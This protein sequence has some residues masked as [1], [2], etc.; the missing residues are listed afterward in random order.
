MKALEY[1]Y[2]LRRVYNSGRDYNSSADADIYRK[3]DRA[4]L[5]LKS[6]YHTNA[7]EGKEYEYRC[8]FSAVRNHISQ[9]LA[10]GIKQIKHQAA[11]E[12]IQ[13]LQKIAGMLRMDYYDREGLDQIIEE[14][15][16]VFRKY[17][18]QGR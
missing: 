6:P 13:Q 8:T 14:A 12:E 3:M 5:H 18:L 15:D 9:A 4:Y 2:L 1:E 17:G 11:E 16:E 10:A 7:Q